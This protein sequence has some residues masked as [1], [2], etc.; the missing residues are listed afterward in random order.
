MSHLATTGDSVTTTKAGT[1]VIKLDDHVM[2]H[3]M[4]ALL[5]NKV[6][7]AN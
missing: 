1:A 6:A 3:L 7:N 4:I 5:S 2:L